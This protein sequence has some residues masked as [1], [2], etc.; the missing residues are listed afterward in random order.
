MATIIS[1]PESDFPASFE[2]ARKVDKLLTSG[3]S[4]SPIGGYY[5]LIVDYGGDQ[6]FGDSESF[7]VGSRKIL[8][9]QSKTRT[10]TSCRRLDVFQPVENYRFGVLE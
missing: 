9:W 10:R 2:I 6:A 1:N 4:F 7:R 8:N 5:G 3:K